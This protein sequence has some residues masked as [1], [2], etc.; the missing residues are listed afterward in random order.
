VGKKLTRFFIYW[1]GGISVGILTY[2]RDQVKQKE[3]S[4]IFVNYI[5]QVLFGKEIDKIENCLLHDTGNGEFFQTNSE[6]WLYYCRCKHKAYDLIGLVCRY[7]NLPILGILDREISREAVAIFL[8]ELFSEGNTAKR[9]KELNEVNPMH[10]DI[11]FYVKVYLNA[12]MCFKILSQHKLDL[13]LMGLEDI[14]KRETTYIQRF[15]RNCAQ[16]LG[17]DEVEIEKIFTEIKDI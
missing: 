5:I 12:L 17:I 14:D 6:N 2:Y 15:K 9:I 10:K 16:K 7:Y 8:L 3:K 11:Y 4:K 1:K 13:L